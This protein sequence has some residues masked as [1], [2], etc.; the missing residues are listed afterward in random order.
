MTYIADTAFKKDALH[1]NGLKFKTIPDA[2]AMKKMYSEF[3]RGNYEQEFKELIEGNYQGGKHAFTYQ[4]YHFHYVDKRSRTETYTDSNGNSRS[5]NT[6]T[7]DHFDRYGLL[8][9]V[10]G[11][12]HIQIIG[13]KLATQYSQSY[14]TASLAFRENFKVRSEDPITA[15]KLLQPTIVVELEALA[16]VFNKINIE[17]PANG[18]LCLSFKDKDLLDGERK[19]SLHKPKEFYESLRGNTELEKLNLALNFIHSVIDTSQ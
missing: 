13:D 2:A 19:H 18:I 5:R 11:I 8:A 12:K 17:I 15:A 16:D 3:D 1:D 10:P 7:F 4:Y 14:Q 9:P 6:V